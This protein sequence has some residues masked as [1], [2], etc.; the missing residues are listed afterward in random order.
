MN[1]ETFEKIKEVLSELAI[2]PIDIHGD[3]D[4]HNI[5]VVLWF[6]RKA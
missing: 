1:L 5:K 6:P 3:E 2:Q 4:K